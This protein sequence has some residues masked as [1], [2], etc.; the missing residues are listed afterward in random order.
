[1]CF[2]FSTQ[3]VAKKFPAPVGGGLIGTEDFERTG[4]FR[5]QS[6]GQ[7][8]PVLILSSGGM[9]N[10]QTPAPLGPSKELGP[11]A[12]PVEA[13]LP[14]DAVVTAEGIY[15]QYGQIRALEEVSISVTRGETLW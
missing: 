8:Q 6:A 2:T 14:S 15:K 9:A 11:S 7:R 3:R 1:M 4:P 5:I 13:P 12:V 10:Q